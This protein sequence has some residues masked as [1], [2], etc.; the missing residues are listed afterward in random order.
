MLTKQYN[1]NSCVYKAV[2]TYQQVACFPV[3]V[4]IKRQNPMVYGAN[5]KQCVCTESCT[6]A[7][8]HAY[9]QTHTHART[10][11]NTHTHQR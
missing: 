4:N 5:L 3:S 11:T 2:K 7:R 1:E 9:T 6:H 8:T 10:N